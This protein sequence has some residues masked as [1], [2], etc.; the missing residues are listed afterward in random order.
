MP[1]IIQNHKNKMK[2]IVFINK[3]DTYK[4]IINVQL[5]FVFNRIMIFSLYITLCRPVTCCYVVKDYF[6]AQM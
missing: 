3:P 6:T 4:F 2:I 5:L 1:R